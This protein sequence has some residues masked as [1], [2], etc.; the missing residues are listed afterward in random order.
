[1]RFLILEDDTQRVNFFIERFG[2]HH[3]DITE[4]AFDAIEY[5]KK[6]TYDYIF[7]DNDLGTGNGEGLDVA[8]F[9]ERATNPNCGTTIVIHSW[10]TVA[11]SN[12]L[13]C[14]PGSNMAPYGTD[15]FYDL[16]CYI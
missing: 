1:M 13:K 2:Q 12:M 8:K 4:D 6:F 11:A 10:N 15:R 16:L 9:L 14:I 7:L 3:L 5:L